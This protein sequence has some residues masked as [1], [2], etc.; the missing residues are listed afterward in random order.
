MISKNLLTYS[1]LQQYMETNN[2]VISPAHYAQTGLVRHFNIS[3][4]ED[5]IFMSPQNS[6]K[7]LPG[8]VSYPTRLETCVTLEQNFFSRK[9]LR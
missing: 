5:D 1:Q 2:E 4:L 7:Q 6:G 8:C 9:L 3:A